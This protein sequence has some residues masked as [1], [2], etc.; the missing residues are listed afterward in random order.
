LQIAAPGCHAFQLLCVPLQAENIVREV[1]KAFFA[2]TARDD[3]RCVWCSKSAIL[4][5]SVSIANGP[6]PCGR[7]FEPRG[8]CFA[9]LGIW[10]LFIFGTAPSKLGRYQNE[11]MV[12]LEETRSILRRLES[13]LTFSAGVCSRK[14]TSIAQ[15]CSTYV[16]NKGLRVLRVSD[17]SRTIPQASAGDTPQRSTI[18]IAIRNNSSH[19]L[20]G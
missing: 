13:M 4:P 1:N 17:T 7:G 12:R 11:V 20:F 9:D 3:G 6:S 14:L 15:G 5:S 10:K 8:G 18:A 19:S 2:A 16:P